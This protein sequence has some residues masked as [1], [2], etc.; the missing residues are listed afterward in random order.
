MFLYGQSTSS[1]VSHGLQPS[2][3]LYILTFRAS[4]RE[5]MR[6]ELSS[7]D[8]HNNHRNPRT[9][10]R[11]TS[12]HCTPQEY[13]RGRIIGHTLPAQWQLAGLESRRDDGRVVGLHPLRG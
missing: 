10:R 4:F 3:S 12:H 6:F 9:R 13:A 11:H 2:N 1:T 5:K 7:W 8:E